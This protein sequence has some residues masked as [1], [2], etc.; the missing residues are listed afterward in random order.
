V[1]IAIIGLLSTLAVVSLS[2]ARQKARDAKRMSDLKQIST[3][4][5]LYSSDQAT[6]AYPTNGAACGADII[7]VADTAAIDN[8]CGSGN[9]ITDGTNI[10]LQSI[11]DDPGTTTYHYEGDGDNY[12]ISAALE[13]AAFFVCLN[14]SC[15]ERAGDCTEAGI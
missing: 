2:N 12:C 7:S 10:Y 11:P 9:S 4:I 5:E 15:Y 8:L 3:A 1:V 13:G 14:G 6:S